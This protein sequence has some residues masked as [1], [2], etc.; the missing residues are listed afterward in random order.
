M[1]KLLLYLLVLSA[2]EAITVCVLHFAGG[3]NI[4]AAALIGPALTQLS[5]KV[6]F[7]RQSAKF[8]PYKVEIALQ[9]DR[10][11]ADLNIST[12]TASSNNVFQFFAVSP[13]CFATSDS[14]RF[15]EVISINHLPLAPREGVGP[16]RV[17]L[18]PSFFFRP[19]SEGYEFGIKFDCEYW[20][21]IK[22]NL[23]PFLKSLPQRAEG[24]VILGI[25]PKGYIPDHIRS[26]LDETA[27]ISNVDRRQKRWVKRLRE[28]SWELNWETPG[29]IDHRYLRVTYA[30]LD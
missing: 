29:Q 20:E 15:S 8:R 3:L 24:T 26:R 17:S 27:S 1:A 21:F 25:L 5:F 12:N 18:V 11:M 16:D 13:R 22:A 10:L 6:Y 9:H 14:R 19:S 4:W 7:L 2:V 28:A 23:S 30:S